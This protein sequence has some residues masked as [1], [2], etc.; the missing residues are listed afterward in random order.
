MLDKIGKTREAHE[1][2]NASKMTFLWQRVAK[3]AVQK[4]YM[5]NDQY[6]PIK[7]HSNVNNGLDQMFSLKTKAMIEQERTKKGD[8]NV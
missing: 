5:F 3:I 1:L 6:I 2:Q 8:K 4:M 7:K